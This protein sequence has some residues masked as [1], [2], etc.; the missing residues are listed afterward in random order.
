MKFDFIV[1]HNSVDSIFMEII[2]QLGYFKTVFGKLF[3]RIVKQRKIV[4]LKMD[5]PSGSNIL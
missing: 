1:G 2:R 5:F 4:C 3:Q